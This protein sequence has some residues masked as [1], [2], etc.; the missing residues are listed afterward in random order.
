MVRKVFGIRCGDKPVQLFKK[1]DNS[2]L[3]DVYKGANSRPDL[4]V[5]IT[6]LKDLKSR[7]WMQLSGCGILSVWQPLLILAVVTYL[8]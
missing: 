7:M 3:R 4:H 6:L 5:A 1:S 8:D 2:E